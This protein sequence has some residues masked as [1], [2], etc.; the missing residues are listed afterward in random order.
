MSERSYFFAQKHFTGALL[1]QPVALDHLFDKE[2]LASL[3]GRCG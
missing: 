2:I 1:T 3:G